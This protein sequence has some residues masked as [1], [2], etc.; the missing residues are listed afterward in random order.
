MW[1]TLAGSSCSAR[2]RYNLLLSLREVA[3]RRNKATPT[4]I[5][6]SACARTH[7]L[8][9]LS[10]KPPAI[11]SRGFRQGRR[12]AWT[13]LPRH[14]H[15]S[16]AA[17][18]RKGFGSCA[19]ARKSLGARPLS[20]PPAT[21]CQRSSTSLAQLSGS[22]LRPLCWRSMQPCRRSGG[23]RTASSKNWLF[24]SCARGW[25]SIES[26]GRLWPLPATQVHVG[27]LATPRLERASHPPFA[28]RG[29][30]PGGLHA[31]NSPCVN[32]TST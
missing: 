31:G 3:P 6:A 20:E 27:Q 25:Y 29:P 32:P 30:A 18:Y 5:T 23:G 10:S 1:C 12:E 17:P 13:P 8:P 24:R 9:G 4:N 19:G 22:S 14:L 26:A 11:C 21:L 7:K 15:P 28:T 16:A 2:D